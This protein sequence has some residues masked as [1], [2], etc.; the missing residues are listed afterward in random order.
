M[1]AIDSM[2]GFSRLQRLLSVA[3]IAVMA[4]NM[5]GQTPTQQPQA[6]KE[7]Q[8]LYRLRVE[9]ELVLVN[10][11][12]RDKQGK[13][14]TDLKRDDFTVLEEGKPQRVSSFDFENLD[15]QPIAAADAGPAQQ[16]TNGPAVKQVK[17][18]LTAKDADQ[19]LSNKRVIVMFFDLGSMNPDET[20]RSVQAA[21][22]YIQSKMTSADLIAIVTLASSLRLDQDFTGDK[23][24]LLRVLNRFTHSEGQGMDN[25]PTGDPEGLGETG[26]AYTP[27][28][29]EYNQF[30][31]DRKLQ[32]LQSLCQ[33][34]AKFNQKKSIIYFS[35]GMTQTG[36]ENQSALRSAINTAIKANVAI[37]TTDSRGLEAEPPG[38][39]AATASLHGTGMYS[40]AAVQS[41]FDANFASQETLTT[42][43]GDTGGKAFL[44]TNDLGQVFD[45]V[46]RDTSVYYVLGYKSSNEL[47]DGKYRRIQVKVN[48]PGVNLEFRK[49]YYAPK[50][51]QHFNAEDKEQQMEDELASELP[52]TDVA[53]YMAA[54]YFRMDDRRFYVPVA[55]VVPG[56]QIPFTKGGDKDKATLDIIG[57]VMD[58]LKRV[59]GSVRETVKLSLDVSQE[60]R[61]KNVQYS[62]GFLLAPGKYHFKFVVRENQSG[63]LGSFEA[64]FV[65]PDIKKAPLRMSSVV[66]ASQRQPATRKTQNPLVR[67]GSELVPNIAHVFTTEQHLYFFYEVYD[68]AKDKSPEPAVD[69]K[70]KSAPIKNPIHLITSI[71]FFNGKVKAFETPLIESRQLNAP[72]RKAAVFQFDVSLAQLKPGLYTCQVNVIDDAGGN[73]SFPRLPILVREK[74]AP[75]P[76]ITTGS[77]SSSR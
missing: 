11:V 45:R 61:R 71:Q 13:P 29:T 24:R 26:D 51:F 10:V 1:P 42:L 33:V 50:D 8:G 65:V 40:G 20:E 76:Q 74:A 60:V 28:E 53:L 62:T 72:E 31:T 9:S 15:M 36:I 39:S 73:F 30:N 14:V 56:S 67:D 69:A 4:T 38:G 68:P 23:P 52:N 17:P 25:G 41:Q 37:Y 59:V 18:I 19:A 2:R 48:R 27:D 77:S 32:A 70:E 3:L 6:D 66:L 43:A 46:Q 57:D 5:P 55:L 16:T 54:S 34:L 75:A 64:D 47:R 7:K 22:K 44:D 21:K 12:V 49:G 63:R 35:S 58:E